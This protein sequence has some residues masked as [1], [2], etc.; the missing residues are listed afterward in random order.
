MTTLFAMAA[1]LELM[2][3]VSYGHLLMSRIDR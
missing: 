1:K 3:A 2:Q